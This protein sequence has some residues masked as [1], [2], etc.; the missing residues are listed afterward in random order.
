MMRN[1]FFNRKIL[2]SV[3]AVVMCLGFTAMS[4]G[5]ATVSVEPAEVESPAAGEE[6]TVSINIAGGAD[7]AG[8]QVTLNFDPTALSYVSRKNA[9]YLPEGSFEVPAVLVEGGDTIDESSVTIDESSVTIAATSLTGPASDVDG[10][11]A[12]VTFEVVAAKA[13]T[14]GLTGVIIS[15]AAGQ[16]LEVATIMDGMVTVG[17]GDTEADGE[18]DGDTEA[19]G[20]TDGDTEADGETDGDT[21]AD[22]ETDGDTEADGETDGDT[23]A[24]GETDGDT[25]AD[26][27]TDGDTEADG[28]META[29]HTEPGMPTYQ[30]FEIT[31]TNLTMGEAGM[32]GQILSPPIFAAHP[33]G[34]NIA[35]VGEAPSEALI[36][37]AENGDTSGLAE[38]ADAAHANIAIAEDVVPPGGSVTVTITADMVN[39]SLSVASMLVS[40]NDAFIAATDVAL[41]DADGMAV[42]AEIELMAYDAGSEDNT[43]AASDIPGPLGLDPAVDP[44]GSNERVPTVDGVIASHA[45]IQ[46]G[47]DVSEAFAWSEPTAMLTITPVAAPMEPEPEPV[48]P[49][50]A[51][52]S[53]MFEITLTNL[54]MGEAGMGGQILSPPIFAAH[55]AGINIAPVGEAPSEALI[56]LAENGDTS[57]LAEIADAAHA[58][59]AMA[60][61]VVPPGGSVTVTITA[62][63]VNSSLSVASMLVSTNDAFIAAT[64]VALFDA[65]GMAVSAE[66]ELMA[67]DAG[68]EDNTEAAS[69]IPGPLG[70]DPAVD[71]EGSN[72]RVPTVDGVIASHAGIQGGGDV[73]EAFAWSEP[74][75]MLTITPVAAH[76]EPEP[77][78]PGFDVMLEPGLNMISVPL[79]PEEPYTAKSLAEMLGATVVIQLNTATQ[80]FVGYTVADGGDGFSID[81]G[82]GYIVNTPA[83][84]M[85]KFTGNAWDNQPE[86]VPVVEEPGVEEPAANGDAA[87]DDAA[88]DDEA[89]DDEAH[90]D[91]AAAAPALSTFK[92]AWAFI[93]TSDVQ[94]METGTTYTLVAENLRNSTQATQNIT[95]GIKQ[96]T[97]VWADLNRKNVIEAGDRLK[98]AL[99]DDHGRIVSGPF[100]RTV[101]TADI[102]NAFLSVDL[103]VGDVHPQETLLAQNFP[104]PFN[105]ETWIPYQLSEA[106]E[107]SIHIYDVSGRLVRT[108]DVG[109]QPVG[110]YMTPSRAAYWDGRNAIGER[111]ASGIYFY[112]LQTA[113]FAAT[114]R[115]VILK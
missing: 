60:K 19:D 59:I 99:Y 45:G 13:S 81:G 29:D 5:Q 22:G 75:A 110:S 80:S 87:H 78:V 18:T 3:L 106:T 84:G 21:E 16:A 54:T 7:V 30:M 37:L 74:T 96:A 89:H 42:S 94:N 47:G 15:D 14:I 38:I 107:V 56:A 32:G 65:D 4:Y 88:H 44:E 31:L 40:T 27:E 108:L 17:H 23:E 57:G 26:G 52:E 77:I 36:A 111:V 114:Q 68:S 25:E 49:E 24:D 76:V 10:T 64:D 34:I 103:T 101:T 9:D 33:A 102:R 112:T 83:G 20:E 115:M 28:E 55:P 61:D 70:L 98:I 73:S 48:E 85:A 104:N 105:P 90:D 82:K 53:E 86:P 8:Y 113:D 58:N 92:S 91:V 95:T 50:P 2:F 97:A 12:T 67:Y 63:M 93:V 100:Q 66:I 35:P 71:P 6:L 69:D 46:G 1:Q 51:P 109:W 41:F 79:M 62:D 72:E 43:E 39:S 11:L